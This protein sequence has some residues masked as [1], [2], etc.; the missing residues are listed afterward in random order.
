MKGKTS[1]YVLILEIIIICIFHTVKIL[2]TGHNI[3]KNQELKFSLLKKSI[4]F[5]KFSRDIVK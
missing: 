3:P 1:H 5:N 4:P 2:H